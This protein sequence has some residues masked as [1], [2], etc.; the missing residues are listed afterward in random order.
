MALRSGIQ[1]NGADLR[2]LKKRIKELDDFETKDLDKIM[3]HEATQA[4][5]RMK[6]DSPHDT[7]RLR[8]NIHYDSGFHDVTFYSEAIDP[9]TGRDYAVAQE[10][11]IGVVGKPYFR[12]NIDLFF[13]KLRDRL[14][15]RLNQ[16]NTRR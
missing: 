12:K 8:R 13:I 15:R 3:R 5:G 10:Y 1:L 9:K 2:T 14:A 4:V 16:I 11:G 7:G 6:K